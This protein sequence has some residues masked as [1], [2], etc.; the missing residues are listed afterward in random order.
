MEIKINGIPYKISLMEPNTRADEN[1]G[2]CDIKLGIITIQRYM[3]DEIQFSTLIHE[4]IEAISGMHELN[5]KHNVISCL[6]TNLAE[7]LMNND[8]NDF[9]ALR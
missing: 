8:I 6:S 4:I 5:L 9:K 2:K 7:V 1:M 3:P